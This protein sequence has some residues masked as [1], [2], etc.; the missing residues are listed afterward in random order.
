MI[1]RYLYRQS[2]PSANPLNRQE[3]AARE[4]R[5]RR[6]SRLKTQAD[7]SKRKK[8]PGRDKGFND[9]SSV[10]GS[11][12]VPV[13]PTLLPDEILA[14][15]PIVRPP[16]PPSPDQNKTKSKP[17]KFFESETRH[18]KDFQ[19]G[20][21]K[22][23]VMETSHGRLAPKVGK[24]SKSLKE[25]WLAGRQGR[26]GEGGFERRKIGGGFLRR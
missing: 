20:S 4:K 9:F 26:K 25:S 24:A 23:R 18:P 5:K 11:G 22:V 8:R 15:E 17:H 21:V 1:Y 16:T 7:S 10:E 6:D 3:A 19:R 12:R 14:R 2:D 13:I